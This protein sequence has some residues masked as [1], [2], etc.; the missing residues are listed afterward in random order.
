[1]Q[2]Q[3]SR[4]S[5]VVSFSRE[6]FVSPNKRVTSNKNL[7]TMKRHASRLGILALFG[8][9][10]VGIAQSAKANLIVNGGFET[11]TFGGWTQTG[12]TSFTFVNGEPRPGSS[13]NFAAWFGAGSLGESSSHSRQPPGRLTI[14]I[15]G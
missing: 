13:G 6:Q 11:G 1:M 10:T 7:T 2:R 4:S 12:N 15:S 5:V 3:V 9:L 8:L 14:S